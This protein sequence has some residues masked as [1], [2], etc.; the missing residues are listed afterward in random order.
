MAVCLLV[1]ILV[2][3]SF[4]SM[5]ARGGKVVGEKYLSLTKRL[6]EISGKRGRTRDNPR[7]RGES[8]RECTCFNPQSAASTQEEET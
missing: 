1:L 2:F 6:R 5:S 4:F 3:V 8:L 7:Y